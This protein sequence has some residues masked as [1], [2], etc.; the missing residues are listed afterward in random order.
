M[1][2]TDSA[3]PASRAGALATIVIGTAISVLASNIANV[4]LPTMAHELNAS[5]STSIWV[6]NAYQLAV[7]VTLLPFASFGDIHGYRRVYFIGLV[8]FTLSSIACGLADSLPM[9]VAARVV[10]ALGSAGIMSVNSALIRYIFPPHQLG[11]GISVTTLTVAVCAASGPSIAA[12]ILAFASW[13]WLFA[14][15]APF[16]LLALWL[17]WR[18]L[19]R[20]PPSPHRFEWSSAVLN[21]MTFGLLLIGLDG[22]GH[23]QDRML[24]A[25]ELLVGSLAG[26]VFV[27]RQSRVSAPML[28]VDLFRLPI[29]A[30]SVLTSVCTYAAQTIAFL[31]LPFYFQVVGG[32]TQSETGLLITPWPAVIMGVAPLSGRLSDRYPAGLLGGVGLAILTVGLALVW[33]LPPDAAF[34]DV[35]WRMMVCG[36]GFGFFQ[37]PNNR[38]MIGSAPRHRSGAASGMTSTARLTGQTIGGVVVAMVFAVMHGDLTQAVHVTLIVACAFTAAACVVSFLRLTQSQV[39]GV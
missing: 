24:V 39:S 1:T 22:L 27:R 28:P 33:L 20:T 14:F 4:A 18:Y 11:R 26:Y 10:Q 12:G 8:L 37:S 13:H 17:G 29:F 21:A 15:N 2:E 23:G 19:P 38:A 35:C 6:V 30:L 5:P 7:T 31:S 34:L 25:G 16:G 3:K 9:L 36:I 32:H